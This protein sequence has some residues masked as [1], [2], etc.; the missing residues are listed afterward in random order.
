MPSSFKARLLR[1]TAAAQGF[2]YRA[3][4]VQPSSNGSGDLPP[5]A[6][7]LWGEDPPPEPQAPSRTGPTEEEAQAREQQAWQR[8]F[9]AASA[10]AQ[11]KIDKAVAAE[12]AALAAALAEFAQRRDVYYQRI[13]GEIVSLVLS[14]ARKVLHR[15]SQMDPMLLT[16]IVR[17][18]LERIAHA[19]KITLRVPPSQAESWQAALRSMPRKDLDVAVLPDDALKV[20]SCLIVTEMGT[21]EVSVEGQLEE[22]ERGFLDLLADRPDSASLCAIPQTT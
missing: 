15:E 11:E 13:E 1:R 7:L 21:T 19:T 18:A 6:E 9:A 5:G 16:G 3:S 8:G 10:Q 20:P 4:E 17:V 2:V 12:R 22:I 14:I